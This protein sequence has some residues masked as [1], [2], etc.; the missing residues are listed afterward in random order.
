MRGR[1]LLTV[2]PPSANCSATATA[3]EHR[4]SESCSWPNQATTQ[5]D[6]TCLLTHP[7][8]QFAEKVSWVVARQPLRFCHWSF[9]P[10]DEIA[11]PTAANAT[12]F[13]FGND[14]NR[15][16]ANSD[17]PFPGTAPRGLAMARTARVGHFEARVPHP[18]GLCDMAGNVSE[19]CENL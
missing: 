16:Q 12:A 6:E 19:W 15:E 4:G 2:L 17:G 1:V 8:A 18:W 11:H 7:S 14:L 5:I 3:P 13:Y 9:L 10:Q